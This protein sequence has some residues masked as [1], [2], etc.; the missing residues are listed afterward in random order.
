MRIM[1]NQRHRFIFFNPGN[2]QDKRVPRGQNVNLIAKLSIIIVFTL[3]LSSC[4]SDYYPKPRGYIRIALPEKEYVKF[5]TTYPFTFEYPVYSRFV[6]DTDANA[7]PYWFNLDFP[8][9][10]GRLNVSYKTVNNNVIKYLEDTR[11][12]VM[13]HIP[14]ANAIESKQFVDEKNRIYGLTYTIKGPEAASPFQFYLTDSTK[15]FVRGALYFYTVPNND[16]LAP[17]IKFLK[18]DIVHM[19]ETFRWKP[20]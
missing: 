14:K 16:S 8:R 7:E 6:P 1:N 9:F 5:D 2:F 13:K 15:N 11:T 3:F 4:G 19:I 10:K 17:V 18:Q 20:E 12:L